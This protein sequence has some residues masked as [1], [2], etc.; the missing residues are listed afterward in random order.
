MGRQ[1]QKCGLE[2]QLIAR[3]GT[4]LS[5]VMKPLKAQRPPS[6]QPSPPHP[7]YPHPPNTHRATPTAQPTCCVRMQKRQR[8]ASCCLG[9]IRAMKRTIWLW[10]LLP[11]RVGGAVLCCA[12][13]AVWC[14]GSASA[15]VCV[16][17]DFGVTCAAV[18]AAWSGWGDVRCLVR[19]MQNES[20]C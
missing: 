1:W 16:G 20:R 3:L 18:C 13:C 6:L 15:L 5:G 7:T 10:R 19:W 2:T 8:G 12:V 4:R 9:L 14:C 17:V 11:C